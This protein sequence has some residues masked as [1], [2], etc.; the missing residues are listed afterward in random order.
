MPSP[1]ACSCQPGLLNPSPGLTFHPLVLE[2]A[3]SM[4]LDDVGHQ[5]FSVSENPLDSGRSGPADSVCARFAVRCQTWAAI[6]GPR[7]KV[8]IWE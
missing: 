7:R 5:A 2:C 8:R 6:R 1:T 3:T 4:Y